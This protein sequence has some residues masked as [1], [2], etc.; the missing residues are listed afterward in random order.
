MKV[1]SGSNASRAGKLTVAAQRFRTSDPDQSRTRMTVQAL[2]ASHRTA[3]IVA[4]SAETLNASD[5]VEVLGNRP[6]HPQ[7]LGP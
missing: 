7:R 1:W 6:S 2:T 4:N 3:D 5:M